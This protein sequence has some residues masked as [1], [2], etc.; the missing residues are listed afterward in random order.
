MASYSII[1]DSGILIVSNLTDKTKTH[2]DLSNIVSFKEEEVESVSMITLKT[3]KNWNL[4]LKTKTGEEL[5]LN[6][7]GDEDGEENF[8][9]TVA[10]MTLYFYTRNIR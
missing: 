1:P 8:K 4:I 6:F 9:K 5:E 7:Y 2:H 3:Q 10:A